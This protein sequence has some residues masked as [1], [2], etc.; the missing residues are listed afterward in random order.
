[1]AADIHR[2]TE[3]LVVQ[4]VAVDQME[5][6][7]QTAEQEHP[8]KVAT[9]VVLPVLQQIHTHPAAAVEPVQ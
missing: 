6:E 3:P 4:V 8:A 7:H 2:Q 9:V 5:L 1:M